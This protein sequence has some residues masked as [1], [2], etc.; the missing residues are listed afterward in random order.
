MHL[1]YDY[2]TLCQ[3]KKSYTPHANICTWIYF[4]CIYIHLNPCFSKS[5]CRQAWRKIEI[6]S[7]VCVYKLNLSISV[8]AVEMCMI[9][10]CVCARVGSNT[11][12]TER[13]VGLD[14]H[15]A[16]SAMNAIFKS[17]ACPHSPCYAKMHRPEQTPTSEWQWIEPSPGVNFVY[18]V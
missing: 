13:W 5:S 8:L 11:Q 10:F 18:V 9:C 1:T 7:F 15:L 6:F 3:K 12:P 16:S 17:L 14:Y 4:A 2:Q